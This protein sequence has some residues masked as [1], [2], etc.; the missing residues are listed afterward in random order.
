MRIIF[1]LLFIKSI[2]F[3]SDDLNQTSL[4]MFLFKI[5]FTS[6]TNE[7][8]EQKKIIEQNK[9]AILELKKQLEQMNDLK[10]KNKI[11]TKLKINNNLVKNI[12]YQDKSIYATLITNEANIYSDKTYS[13]TVV[14]TIKRGTLLK[15]KECDNYNW[16]RLENYDGYLAKYKLKF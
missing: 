13:S 16:C 7:V 9:I 1:I 10:S 6:L 5:G 14:S 4:D 3:S 12:D 11:L 8:E 15:I 2:I